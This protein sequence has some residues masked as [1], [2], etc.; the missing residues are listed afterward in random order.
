MLKEEEKKEEPIR[1]LPTRRRIHSEI[2][3]ILVNKL[4]RIVENI[5]VLPSGELNFK[6]Y[7]DH[8]LLQIET[9][10]EKKFKTKIFSQKVDIQTAT[11]L[12]K[13]KI[14]RER[15]DFKLLFNR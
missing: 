8:L 13:V 4:F 3:E 5:E 2:E 11:F 6:P 7:D 1:D 14:E 15:R 10:L 12:E 9:F